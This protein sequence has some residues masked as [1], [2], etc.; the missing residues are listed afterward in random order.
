KSFEQQRD[1]ALNR[2]AS[3]IANLPNVRALMTI[4]DEA[5]IEDASYDIQ[6]LS[7]SDLLVLADRTGT[8]KAVRSKT[9]D[10]PKPMAQELL[11]KSIAVGEAQGFWYGGGSLYEI[12]V[13]PIDFGEGPS[14]TTIGL[15]IVGYK[16]DHAA[17][18]S[19]GDLAASEVAF[20]W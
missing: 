7:G 10:F 20:R 9:E 18:R 6:R 13:Q 5:T 15:L 11:Q 12:L 14:K 3:L 4:P 19:F 1:A 8:V 16:I 17:A 2:A